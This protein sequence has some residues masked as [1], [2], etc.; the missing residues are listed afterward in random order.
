[1]LEQDELIF[2]VEENIMVELK[3]S[4]KLDDVHLAQEIITNDYNLNIPRYVDTFK[5]EESIDTNAIASQLKGL[6]TEMKATE[7]DIVKFYKKLKIDTRF[8]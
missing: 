8:F 5:A 6:E 1:M 4:I 7:N 3:A 2:F